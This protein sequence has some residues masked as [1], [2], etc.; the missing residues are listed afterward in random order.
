MRHPSDEKDAAT[1]DGKYI[2]HLE[3][4]LEAAQASLAD[5]EA[6]LKA[7]NIS[8]DEWMAWYDRKSEEEN[9]TQQ[10]VDELE[11]ELHLSKT[12]EE[13]LQDSLEHSRLREQELERCLDAAHAATEAAEAGNIRLE[14]R[15]SVMSDLLAESP[16]KLDLHTGQGH[17]RQR[18]DV[19]QFPFPPMASPTH[20]PSPTRRMRK[21]R[22]S[23]GIKP[24]IL[25]S[26][27]VR[28]DSAHQS[29]RDVT[30]IHTSRGPSGLF[31]NFD[32]SGSP[33]SRN[34]SPTPPHLRTFTPPQRNLLQELEAYQ[35]PDFWTSTP[36]SSRAVSRASTPERPEALARIDRV[37][38]RIAQHPV[39]WIAGAVVGACAYGASKMRMRK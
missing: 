11:H 25:S 4:E 9:T 30:P 39:F 32:N 8:L 12:R 33:F 2:D 5:S 34:N 28:H 18:S 17:T 19:P 6:Q 35:S 10:R 26:T 3:T 23:L 14:K 29:P 38:L 22:G 1:S 15:L 21:M 37:V 27:I 24:L 20:E 7:I 31:K 36:C 16:T 13:E